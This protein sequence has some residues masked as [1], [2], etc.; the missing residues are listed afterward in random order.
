MTLLDMQR[1][2]SR[3]LTD[4]DFQRSFI[5]GAE[6]LPDTYQ[7]TESELRSLRSLR[8]DR[9]GLHADLLAH[10]RLELA[11]RALPLT[12]QLVH[13]QLH[14]HLDRFCTE[15]PPVPQP[16]STLFVE[17][18]RLCDF[19]IRLLGEGALQ[20]GWAADIV[21]YE[22]IMLTLVMT[23]ES[24]MSAERV[25]SLNA[26]LSLL[27]PGWPPADAADLVPVAGPHAMVASF[28]YPLPELL[29]PLE[30]GDIPE[31]VAPLER[32]IL[33]LFHKQP[34]GS[35]QMV[36]VNAPSAALVE[37]CDGERTVADVVGLLDRRFGPGVEA[38]VL[39][40]LGWLCERG[41]VGLRKGR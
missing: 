21:A 36:K 15:F 1:V 40:A 12:S 25:A 26:E 29:P 5:L 20:P 14:T 35:V 27:E 33:L 23:V 28:S 4:K 18:N 6:P 9:V 31:N 32:P 16:A 30:E 13:Q 34:L 10:G 11:L 17:A 24:A 41:V 39:A 19:L 22:R 2:L 8:W 3:I 38:P 37:A 7:L